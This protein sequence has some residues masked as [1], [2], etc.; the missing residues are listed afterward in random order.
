MCLSRSAPVAALS[1]MLSVA[2]QAALI[3][4]YAH[5][6]GGTNTDALN[7]LA[8]RATFDRSGNVLS[9]LLENTST[10]VPTSFAAAD[11]LLV[12]LGFDLPT[13]V[14]ILSGDTATI[15]LGSLGIGSW[16]GWTA[17]HTVA[18]EWLWTNDYGGDLMD[19]GQ[20]LASRQVISTSS[21]QG[22]GVSTL[23][24]GGSPS[25]DGPYGGIAA[26]PVLLSVP[27][28]KPAVSNSIL[29]TITLTGGLSDADLVQVA[30][31]AVVEFGSNA[32]YLDAP[33]PATL[34]LVLLPLAF[35][36]R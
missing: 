26:N 4:D 30:H 1:W 16:S 7:G 23:F 32:R 31:G 19:S 33:E 13:G 25:V 36:R 22:E 6:A 21:G 34:L 12:S 27:S 24:G 14:T 18:Q 17:G 20:S 35:R 3:V 28:S 10:G 8:A 5:D 9:V 15:G 2:A 29:F 11:S